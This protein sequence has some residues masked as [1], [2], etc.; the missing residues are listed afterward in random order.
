M[1]DTRWPARCG[2]Q[3]TKANNDE[4]LIPAQVV[5]Q[6]KQFNRPQGIG[7][8]KNEEIN[9]LKLNLIRANDDFLM[10]KCLIGSLGQ[11]S[12]YYEKYDPVTS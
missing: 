8:N 6:I 12:I 5:K 3:Q 4:F 1:L 10:T 9:G 7:R 11:M 2:E